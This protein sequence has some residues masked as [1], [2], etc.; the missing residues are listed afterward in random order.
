MANLQM[1]SNLSK[2]QK[3]NDICK[4]CHLGKQTRSVFLD[5][6]FRAS[7]KLQLVYID[8]CGPIQNEFLNGSKY[9]SLF[10]DD[11]NMYCWVFFLSK[12]D[13]FVEF[14]K[15]KILVELET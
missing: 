4:A 10:I 9:F 13:V 5:K 15:F 8:I 6:N 14:V 11:Y 7:V 12:A 2:I 3:Q 1:A